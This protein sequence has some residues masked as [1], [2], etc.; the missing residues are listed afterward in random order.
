MKW[1]WFCDNC[2]HGPMFGEGLCNKCGNWRP[3]SEVP[4]EHN[5]TLKKLSDRIMEKLK[6][7]L[8][9]K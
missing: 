3:G 8:G 1:G 9:L 2:G 7:D 6:K 5:E 4:F